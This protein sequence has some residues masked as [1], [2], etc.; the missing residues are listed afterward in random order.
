MDDP[1]MCLV[2]GN[3]ETGLYI[4][5]EIT[6][7]YQLAIE[8]NRRY[9]EAY[10]KLRLLLKAL[11]GLDLHPIANA[12]ELFFLS[13]DNQFQA[14]GLA[15]MNDAALA[16]I[17]GKYKY[18]EPSLL[19][20]TEANGTPLERYGVLVAQLYSEPNLNEFF[21]LI[22]RNGRWQILVGRGE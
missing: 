13:D 10:D 12:K 8:R 21:P 18:R 9:G 4:P 1:F 6:D 14:A 16:S 22:Y 17:W 5:K 3:A 15:Q 19:E 20:I 2:E 7:A 11:N